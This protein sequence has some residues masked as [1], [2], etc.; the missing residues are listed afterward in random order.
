MQLIMLCAAS[1]TFFSAS[2]S[3]SAPRCSARTTCAVRLAV[4]GLLSSHHRQR[5]I[6][7]HDRC[8]CSESGAQAQISPMA[9]LSVRQEGGRPGLE[10]AATER[11]FQALRVV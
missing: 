11:A 9:W 7:S 1:H 5:T 2:V 10:A 8:C 4:C 3:P 6:R